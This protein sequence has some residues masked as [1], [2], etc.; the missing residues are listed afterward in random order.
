MCI[1]WTSKEFDN[2]TTSEV[3]CCIII[4]IIENINHI[5]IYKYVNIWD[6]NGTDQYPFK[7]RSNKAMVETLFPNGC[8]NLTKEIT[9]KK[10]FESE[11]NVY[12]VSWN[13]YVILP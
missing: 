13:I 5:I 9:L 8:K 12:E 10:T 1:S 2:F 6:I 4:V 11:I 7:T 3:V